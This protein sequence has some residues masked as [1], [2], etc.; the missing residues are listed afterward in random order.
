MGCDPST[1]AADPTNQYYWRMNSRRMESQVVR[2]SLL[3]FAGRLDPTIGGP[4]IDPGA[5][6]TRRSLYF[7]H[8]VDQQEKFLQMFDDADV[9]QCYRRSESIVPQQALALSNS[10]LAIQMA[11]SIEERVSGSLEQPGRAAFIDEVFYLLLGRTPTDAEVIEC[12]RFFD[13]M[14]ALQ[15]VQQTDGQPAGEHQRRV[16]ARFV[17]AILNHNDFITIR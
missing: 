5:D 7:K 2:D 8:S 16:G 9:L 15:A 11:V 14:G 4:S 17:H 6:T 12:N 3:S 13:E 1:L 10:S